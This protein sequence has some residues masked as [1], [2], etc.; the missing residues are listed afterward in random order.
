MTTSVDDYQL[1]PERCALVS[2]AIKAL[3]GH[4]TMVPAELLAPSAHRSSAL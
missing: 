4:A 3:A 1:D 2:A